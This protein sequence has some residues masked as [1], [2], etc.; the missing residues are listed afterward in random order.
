MKLGSA[1]FVYTSNPK[2]NMRRGA[3]SVTRDSEAHKHMCRC[4]ACR[5]VCDSMGLQGAEKVVST[6]VSLAPCAV[7]LHVRRI[8]AEAKKLSH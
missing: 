4:I 7:S 1:E 2:Y 6:G 3:S 8:S 5:G